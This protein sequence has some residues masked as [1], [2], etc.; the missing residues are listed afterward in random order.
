M[1]GYQK[2]YL[3]WLFMAG[4][5][6]PGCT[7]PKPQNESLSPPLPEATQVV[8]NPT[9]TVPPAPVTSNCKKIA[10][11]IFAKIDS[12]IY[13]ICPDGSG[14]L[15][16]TEGHS[17]DMFPAWSPDGAKIAF[18]SLRSGSSQIYIM[19]EDGS[20]PVQ[21]TSDYANDFPIWLPNGEQ[22]AFRTT[23][24][25][26]LWWWRKINIASNQISPLTEPSYD[27]FFQ[28]PAW[29]PDGQYL[30]YMSLAEQEGRND[31]SSQIHLKKVDGSS[32]VA[33]TN[34]TWANIN[35]VW[36][37]DGTSIAFL[38][39]RDG[40]YNSYAL[41]IISQDGSNLQ[42][43]TSPIFPEFAML[44][45]SPDGQQ[46]AISNDEVPGN[47]YIIN[48]QAKNSRE[49]LHLPDGERASMPAWQP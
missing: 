36:S 31:G 12:D 8:S 10:F 33:L 15:L 1:K 28:T 48:V 13:T 5:L 32:D 34:D 35:P 24:L 37:P 6:L 3:R 22:I 25:N 2:L 20:N 16:L 45:W 30:V 23:D 43:L 27:F 47:I 7:Q 17:D 49:L 39:E 46:I 9:V 38:S 11:V 29:S 26:G 41:Y 14:L 4:L 42:S 40:I 18:A 19:E 44:T 21:L